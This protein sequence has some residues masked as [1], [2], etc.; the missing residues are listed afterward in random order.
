MVEDK[1]YKISE[2]ELKDLV[3]TVGDDVGWPILK[4]FLKDKTPLPE[5]S[6]DNK[7]V[8]IDELKANRDSYVINDNM[9]IVDPIILEEQFE[10]IATNLLSKLLPQQN[11]TEI[12]ETTLNYIKDII[13]PNV[14]KMRKMHNDYPMEFKYWNTICTDLETLYKGD[15]DGR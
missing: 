13:L 9:K 2:E 7:Q 6:K 12:S 11:P 15:K 8:V 5:P 4:D 10:T 1:Y 3:R 14:I